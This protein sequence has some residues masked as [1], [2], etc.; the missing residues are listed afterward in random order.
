MHY[1]MF[2]LQFDLPD[3]HIH[4]V[5]EF[6]FREILKPTG[7]SPNDHEGAMASVENLVQVRH[8]FC[9]LKLVYKNNDVML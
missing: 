3:V 1:S 9:F 8:L 4:R 6:R 7:S 2:H 5:K